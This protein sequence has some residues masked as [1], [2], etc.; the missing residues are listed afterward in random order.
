MSNFYGDNPDLQATL[1]R[2]DLARVVRLR[3]DDYRQA[4]EFAY[5]PRDFEDAL[6]SYERALAIVGDIAGEFVEPRAED[7]DRAGSELVD[8]EV[9]GRVGEVSCLLIV[10]LTQADD[11][12]QVETA[13]R[14][15]QV[16]VVGEEVAHAFVLYALISMGMTLCRSPTMP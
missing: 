11:A 8:G 3:E 5:A 14:G 15:L 13:Q 6:D 9:F 1:R 7:V 12:R 16:R 4:G 2:L 10:V